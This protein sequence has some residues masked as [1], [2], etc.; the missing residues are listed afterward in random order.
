MT[1]YDTLSEALN[2]LK[3]R[4]Y[5]NDFNI[6]CDS[7]ECKHLELKLRPDEFEITEFY[8][9]EGDSNPGDQEVIYAIEST[10]GL[11]GTLVDAYGIYSDDIS[12][13]MIRKLKI[14]R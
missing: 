8:R 5:T 7:L 14:D 11:K 9:F 13:D 3:K 2:D 6:E 12:A 1:S 4:G 10:D